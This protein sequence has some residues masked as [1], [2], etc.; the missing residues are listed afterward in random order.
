MGYQLKEALRDMLT[1]WR[2]DIAPAWRQCLNDVELGF[3][4]V[5]EDLVL[6]PWEPIF[7]SRRGRVFPGAPE[8]A[9]MFRA[10]DNPAPENV[11]CVVLGQDP[12]PCPAFSTGRAFEAGNVARWRE[13]DKMF[14]K[15]VRAFIQLIVAARTGNDA[16]AADFANWPA[17]LTDIEHGRVNLE[18]PE[19]LAD[20]WVN[21]GVLLL[22]SSLTLSRFNVDI[23]D[24]QSRG[25]AALWRPFILAVLTHIAGRGVPT[26]YLGFGDAAARTL[27][28]AGLTESRAPAGQHVILRAHPAAAEQVLGRENPFV[29]C[30]RF[31]QTAGAMPVDW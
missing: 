23:D 1:D 8:K 7:P 21:S 31:L 17:M 12:Y 29:L 20:R 5:A 4:A 11:R 30:N 13:L 10:L 3:D 6:E 14:S 24:H 27:A 16:F 18:G 26:V 25:H 9:H 28:R 15:S 2:Q 19:D 22:N